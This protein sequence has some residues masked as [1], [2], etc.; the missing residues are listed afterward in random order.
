MPGIRQ[1]IVAAEPVQYVDVEAH[2]QKWTLNEEQAR[3]F[4]LIAYHSL[5]DRPDQLR[6]LLTGPGGT[7]KSRVI[8]ALRD[9]FQL[10]GESRRLRLAA[11]TGV[12][13]RNISGMTLHSALCLNQ[14]SNG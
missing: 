14:R 5:Q 3:A 1:D 10:R 4:R 9:L 6:M 13:A 7:G 11:Y 8:D 2:V 12:A